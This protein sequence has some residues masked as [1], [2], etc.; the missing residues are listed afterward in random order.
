MDLGG[1]TPGIAQAI[2]VLFWNQLVDH[3]EHGGGRRPGK[4]GEARP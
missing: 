2:P 3:D 4:G 1:I